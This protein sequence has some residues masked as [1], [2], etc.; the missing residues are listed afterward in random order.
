MRRVEE[1]WLDA[2]QRPAGPKAADT[3]PLIVGFGNA[4]VDATIV[5]PGREM[6][7]FGVAPGADAA[8]ESQERKAE[9]V[10]AV[11]ADARA[12][13]TPG[14]AAL[15]AMRVAAWSG[16]ACVRTAFVGSVGADSN[17]E[18]L[19]RAMATAGAAMAPPSPRGTPSERRRG[20]PRGGRGRS[21]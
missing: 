9:I 10:A 15:N 13:L 4:T 11:A 16:G 8:G 18:V 12:D 6:R 7:A 1:A 3:P 21:A 2:A 14:G 5:L 20:L 19:R 17:A